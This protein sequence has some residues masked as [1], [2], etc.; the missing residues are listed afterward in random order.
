[1]NTR[2][3]LT[4][5]QK[6]ENR[7]LTRQAHYKA[8]KLRIRNEQKSH[9]ENS[10]DKKKSYY[11][12][13]KESISIVKKEYYQ[14]KK[15]GSVIVYS[16]PN[17]NKNGYEKYCG[18]TDCPSTRMRNHKSNGNNTQDW[19]ILGEFKTR[20]EAL[21]VEAKYHEQGYAGKRGFDKQVA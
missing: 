15:L 10:K 14:S 8:N 19:I 16:L 20:E 6:K 1:M 5:E 13:N 17:Y 11:E 4:D 12:T 21:I 3:K 7:R 2:V 18:V 9:Y